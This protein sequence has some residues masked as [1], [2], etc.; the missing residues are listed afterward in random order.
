MDSTAGPVPDR[1]PRYPTSWYFF[2][3]VE[4]LLRGP[5]SR[6]VGGR[7]IVVFRNSHGTLAALDA[8]CSHLGA[9]LGGGTVVEGGIRCPLHGWEYGC[10]GA[11]RKIPAGGAVPGFARQA[12]YPVEEVAGFVF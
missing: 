3:T 10:D 11:C 1:F 9:D 7:R 8:R 4:E 12:T 6:T 2:G 5:V